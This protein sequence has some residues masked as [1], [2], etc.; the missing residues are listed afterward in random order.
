MN[1]F[2]KGD[3]VRTPAGVGEVVAP[4]DIDC[5]YYRVFF[6]EGQ[7]A[8]IRKFRGDELELFLPG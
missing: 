1:E 3:R 5:P 8:T 7:R 2:Q 4:P 6:R